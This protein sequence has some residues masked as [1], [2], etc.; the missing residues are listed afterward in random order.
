VCHDGKEFEFKIERK[1]Y[2]RSSQVQF[3]LNG[4]NKKQTNSGSGSIGA[5]PI[6]SWGN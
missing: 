2:D 5:T 1:P 6:N 3:G 4:P